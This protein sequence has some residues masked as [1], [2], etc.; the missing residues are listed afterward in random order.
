MSQAANQ[1]K[2]CLN[3]ARERL[4]EGKK[5]RGLVEVKTDLK[6]A[7]MHLEKAEHNLNAIAA[8]A[9]IGFSDWSVSAAFYSI[10]HCFLAILARYGYESMNQDCTIAAI[11]HFK[12]QGKVSVEERFIEALQSHAEVKDQHEHSVIELREDYQY[13]VKKEVKDKDR[14]RKFT[15]VCTEMLETAKAEVYKG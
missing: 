3:K 14:I 5:H 6:M 11:Q 8:F 13:G 10:Y 7:A 12:E 2:W 15:Q 9:R 4:A 1:V